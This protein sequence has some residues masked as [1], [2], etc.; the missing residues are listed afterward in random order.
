MGAA[1]LG[2][3]QAGVVKTVNF[4]RDLLELWIFF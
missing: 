4:H 3:E 2:P 1:R